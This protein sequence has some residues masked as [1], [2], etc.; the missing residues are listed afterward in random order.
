MITLGTDISLNLS[1]NFTIAVRIKI[2]ALPTSNGRVFSINADERYVNVSSTGV[3]DYNGAPS[4][5]TLTTG[6]DYTIILTSNRH[7]RSCI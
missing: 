7:K 5:S 3:L 1:T 2:N 4:G 6:T